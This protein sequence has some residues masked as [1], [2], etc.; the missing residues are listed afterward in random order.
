MPISTFFLYFFSIETKPKEKF[1]TPFFNGKHPIFIGSIIAAI[2]GVFIVLLCEFNVNDYWYIISLLILIPTAIYGFSISIVIYFTSFLTIVLVPSLFNE[3]QFFRTNDSE[4]TIFLFTANS[5]FSTFGLFLGRIVSDKKNA[6][7]KETRHIS[8]LHTSA[9]SLKSITSY[10]TNIFE[11]SPNLIAIVRDRD[12]K[13]IELNSEGFILLCLKK[14]DNSPLNINIWEMMSGKDWELIQDCHDL[15]INTFEIILKRHSGPD[16]LCEVLARRIILNDD[17]HY[18]IYA[19]DISQKREAE[20]KLQALAEEKTEL[21]KRV[22]ELKMMALRSAMNPH[23][24]FNCLNSIQFY[25][26]KND[27]KEAVHYLAIFSKLIRNV[28]DFSSKNLI[29]LSTEIEMLRHYITLEQ[30]RFNSQFEVVFDI[31]GSIDL[32]DTEIPPLLIQP[33]IENAIVHGLSHKEKDGKLKILFTKSENKLKCIIEDNG[34]GREYTTAL[35]IKKPSL[36]AHEP[37]AMSLTSERLQ[38]LSDNASE[39]SVNII[40]LKDTNN[41]AIG[42][43]IELLI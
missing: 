28:L 32:Q 34:V 2:L 40:D 31:D 23:F 37:R 10:F 4:I 17:I 9:V 19:T 43:K 22:I 1:M 18:L 11:S 5:I 20:L 12:G 24:I 26:L 42:T 39:T 3:L 33:Y 16:I 21:D 25:I 13:I 7:K 8:E 15:H 30:M 6:I 35:K 38:M 41:K 14:D 29:S 27:K 36:I